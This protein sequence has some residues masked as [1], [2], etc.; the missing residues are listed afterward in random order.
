MY[1]KPCLKNCHVQLCSIYVHI[2]MTDNKTKF[3][4]I[5]FLETS[6]IDT[7]QRKHLSHNTLFQSHVHSINT[8]HEQLALPNLCLIH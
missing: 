2:Q 7:S 4:E 1:R 8:E 6:N 3:F 5:N